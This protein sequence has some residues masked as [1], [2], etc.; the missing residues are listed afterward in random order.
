MAGFLAGFAKCKTVSQPNR[1]TMSRF[2]S[3]FQLSAGL[4]GLSRHDVV[5]HVAIMMD[6]AVFNSSSTA[7]APE[8]AQL[9]KMR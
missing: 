4:P 1:D 6:K 5:I 2:V 8:Q 9:D 3:R 7:N